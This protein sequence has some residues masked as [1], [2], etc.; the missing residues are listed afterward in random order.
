MD[1]NDS[2]QEQNL[3]PSTHNPQAEQ[4]SEEETN[5]PPSSFSDNQ[6]NDELH[7]IELEELAQALEPFGYG[8]NPVT[9]KRGIKLGK[10]PDVLMKFQDSRQTLYLT[11]AQF[12]EL[13]T[14]AKIMPDAYVDDAALAPLLA[15]TKKYNQENRVRTAE[16]PSSSDNDQPAFYTD[17]SSTSPKQQFLSATQSSSSP[18]DQQTNDDSFDQS[19]DNTITFND[20]LHLDPSTLNHSFD[21][22]NLSSLTSNFNPDSSSNDKRKSLPIGF[23]DLQRTRPRPPNRKK[24]SPT[25]VFHPKPSISPKEDNRLV[26]SD[27][28]ITSDSPI[29]LDSP[30]SS[31][32]SSQSPILTPQNLT[33]SSNLN[34]LNLSSLIY[35][36]R[37]RGLYSSSEELLD[38]PQ[39]DQTSNPDQSELLRRIRNDSQ[40]IT[41]TFE[42]GL[43]SDAYPTPSPDFQFSEEAYSIVFRERE[44][45]MTKNKEL[46]H[47][48]SNLV[49]THEYELGSL[50][51][52]LEELKQELAT[53]KKS[54]K[55][56]A[57][58]ESK[59]RIQLG[60]YDEQMS[61]LQKEINN[62]QANYNQTKKRWDDAVSELDKLRAQL[63]SK[64]EEL[65]E[66]QRH[67]QSYTSDTIKWDSERKILEE[68]LKQKNLELH[69]FQLTRH[70]LEQ[71]KQSNSEL[72][73][74]IDKLKFELE[75]QRA[76]Q[77]APN[78][79]TSRPQSL[80]GSL[81]Q[82]FGEEL[83]KVAARGQL[84]D[85][86]YGSDKTEEQD[87][88]ETI[89]KGE[90]GNEGD[91]DIYELFRITRH[92]SSPKT[93]NSAGDEHGGKP[94][95]SEK[96]KQHHV[97]T[98]CEGLIETKSAE[99]Q[100]DGILE[101]PPVYRPK[102]E[103][104]QL[105]TDDIVVVGQR[106]SAGSRPKFSQASL[107]YLDRLV[108]Y[109]NRFFT[110]TF[111]NHVSPI[112]NSSRDGEGMN[113]SI[114]FYS[115][116]LLLLTGYFLGNKVFPDNNPGQLGAL[117]IEM[118]SNPSCNGIGSGMS[119]SVLVRMNSIGAGRE[120]LFVGSTGTRFG[121]LNW[122][123]D[124]GYRMVWDVIAINRRI[125][126]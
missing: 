22:L 52:Q 49:K 39:S 71:Q 21:H 32:Q 26:Q 56:L 99:V 24:K 85:D 63:Q 126:T 35:S 7:S 33:D 44:A 90:P 111:G 93:D 102:T 100:T 119:Q 82:S 18:L 1:S 2:G 19:L 77:S 78:T 68:H 8:K 113:S 110:D 51:E 89:I 109:S 10:L 15:S 43:G 4:K 103:N 64:E 97:S 107:A 25:N 30:F 104:A 14:R 13:E 16:S 37:Q 95:K 29:T 120:G 53:C 94:A 87:P 74:T 41:T 88:V 38:Y 42:S 92:R 65:I 81:R 23:S 70:T 124:L 86:D 5:Q 98:D 91:R 80:V 114:R 123:R 54:G 112:P 34:P 73:A 6:E 57:A 3:D 108:E 28:Q 11:K 69:D 48:I 61:R 83:K 79:L 96:V 9:G 76:R 27:S 50:T 55:E 106:I 17:F 36:N 117:I 66:A 12:Q 59:H 116:I 47:Q 105:Q 84:E 115:S 62:I 67:I 46:S 45:L 20:Q 58:T 101:P 118:V 40:L 121:I 31:N 122:L 75:E 60:E 125:P 72:K